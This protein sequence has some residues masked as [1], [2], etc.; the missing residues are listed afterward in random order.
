MAGPG[1]WR[2]WS[3]DQSCTPRRM[4]R[5]VDEAGVVD[6]VCRA[7]ADGLVV[8]PV[9]SG[10]SFTPLCVTDGVQLDLGALDRLLDVSADG[11]A[12]VQAGMTLHDL[13]VALHAHGRAL[14][15]LGDID[16]QTVGGALATATHGTGAAYRNLSSALVDGRLVA[17]DGAVHRLADPSVPELVPGLLPAAQV[18]LGA[19][20]VLTEVSLRTVPAFRLRKQEEPQPRRDVLAGLDD[21]LARHDHVEFYAVPW[22]GRALVMTSDRTDESAAPPP[23]WRTWLTDELLNNRALELVQR[24]GRRFPSSQPTLARLTGAAMGSSTRL[25]DSHRVF[26]SERR[27]RFVESEWALPRDCAVEALSSVLSLVERRRLPVSFPIEVRFLAG[28]DAL[29]ST[30]HGRETAYVA[31]HQYVGAP[32]E[33]YFS[34][35]EEVMLAL[36]GR[37]HW[38]KRHRADA[39]VLAPR[40]PGWER[41][42]AV[43]SRLDPSGVFLNDHL[44]RTLG[45][46]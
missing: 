19:L 46:R 3:G 30:A 16:K 35:V 5:P 40:Y 10:H 17:A 43:R 34:L 12:R 9:G 32:F 28:D 31:V 25:D 45:L 22:S 8:R 11:V 41:F 33:E 24:T 36:D 26:C 18:S 6:A 1:L 4:E 21:L 37:P 15:N 27:V 14:E 13:S 2:N 38:G 20:G 39:S 7:A 29:L 23:A 44:A 42:A